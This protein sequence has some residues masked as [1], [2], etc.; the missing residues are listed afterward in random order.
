MKEEL[1]GLRPEEAD[2]ANLAP[3]TQPIYSR[4]KRGGWENVDPLPTRREFRATLLAQ[5][6]LATTSPRA[7]RSSFWSAARRAA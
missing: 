6:A 7:Y 4:S 3:A 2:R 1:N 5:P